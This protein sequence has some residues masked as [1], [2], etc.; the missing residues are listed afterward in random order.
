MKYVSL[1]NTKVP[2]AY[3]IDEPGETRKTYIYI[4]LINKCIEVGYD[5][6][7]VAWIGITAML[8]PRGHTFYSQLPLILTDTLVS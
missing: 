5:V 1:D 7:T 4:C 6:I 2:N 3:F 8:L